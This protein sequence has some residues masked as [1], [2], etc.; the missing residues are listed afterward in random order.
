MGT[1]RRSL[2]FYRHLHLH[3]D[4]THTYLFL[5]LSHAHTQT[6]TPTHTS[7]LPLHTNT[8]YIYISLSLSNTYMHSHITFS[9]PHTRNL[10][11]KDSF[12]TSSIR[13]FHID[14]W[15][16]TPTFTRSMRNT[17]LFS[18]KALTRKLQTALDQPNMFVIKRYNRVQQCNK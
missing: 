13:Y 14:I 11:H 7:S 9:L 2:Q 10:A 16:N 5:S 17:S 15:H 18:I 4:P 8:Y 1:T 12:I 3:L 6:H